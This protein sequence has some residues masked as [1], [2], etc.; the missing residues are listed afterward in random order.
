M[1]LLAGKTKSPLYGNMQKKKIKE[2][3]KSKPNT[4]ATVHGW[5]RTV[6]DQ[7]SFAFI[8]VN[9]GSTLGNL[10]VIAD[11]NI[12]GYAEALKDLATGASIIATGELVESPG[13]NQAVELRA[14]EIRVIGKCDPVKY[15]LQKKRHTFEYLRTIAHLR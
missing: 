3:L 10:Q 8:E 2:I 4:H 7:K 5:I 15:P 6:R 1:V 12:K 13:K 14:S 11:A 9:D